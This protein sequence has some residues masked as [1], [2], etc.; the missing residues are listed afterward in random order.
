MYVA[1]GSIF[2]VS[3]LNYVGF[4]FIPIVAVANQL[5]L[6]QIAIIFA[7][8][9]IPYLI[10]IFAGKLGDK[11]NKKLLISM[12]LI[13]MSFFYVLL[14]LHDSFIVILVL[15]FAISLGIALLNPLTSALISSYTQQKDK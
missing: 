13:F 1:L 5:N 3:L 6:S 10:N 8:M 9:R 11:Y 7:V 12:I 4:L 14:G 15:T 2:L